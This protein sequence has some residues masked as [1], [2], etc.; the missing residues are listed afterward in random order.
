[1]DTC[2]QIFGEK[3]GVIEV[4]SLEESSDP[5]R[6]VFLAEESELLDAIS[7]ML[8][9]AIERKQ[10]E[11]ELREQVDF[12]NRLT[13]MVPFGITLIDA[14]DM[15]IT[16]VNRVAAGIIGL[17][18][19]EI[20]GRKCYELICSNKEMCVLSKIVNET[21]TVESSIINSS[22]DPVPI[23]KTAATIRLNQRECILDCFVDISE[24]KKSEYKANQL[25]EIVEKADEGIAI[26]N[27]DGEIQYANQEWVRLHGYESGAQLKGE[28][29]SIF[30][31]EKQ[32]REEILPFNEIVMQCG[33]LTGE[34]GHMRKDGTIFEA[35]NTVTLLKDE[36]GVPHTL[37]N[38]TQDITGRKVIENE[39][40]Q[41]RKFNA[42][43]QLA[44]GIAHEVNTPIQYVGDNT[45]FLGE[46][47]QALSA[48]LGMY[49]ELR[50][51]TE[52]GEVSPEL[53]ERVA[54]AV[55][56]ADVPYLMEEIPL[57]LRQTIEGIDHVSKIV[58]A[59]KE[60]SHPGSEDMEIGDIN[61]ILET[62]ITL[63]RNE[64]KYTADLK[65]S[66][67]P[68]LPGIY[69]LPTEM[70]QVF[71]NIIL[72]AAHAV[73]EKNADTGTKGVITVKTCLKDS[74][75][76][77]QIEDDGP[78][79]PGNIRDRVMEPFFTTKEVGK[80]SGQGLAIARSVVVDKHGGKFTFNTEEGKGTVFTIQLPFTEKM[81]PET[82][83]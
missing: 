10:V 80:G 70:S 4:Y 20:I 81:T 83:R 47:F 40:E 38:F 60:F 55:E 69:C 19:Q 52:H 29:W 16:M 30:H 54:A 26:A 18:P 5:D 56:D 78:G 77:I 42:V 25:A 14:K 63:S 74:F 64:W 8:G 41:S 11:M 17:P 45:R 51:A 15:E 49:E 76:K 32:M 53:V 27:L 82:V 58:L 22:G 72:N 39:L 7:N 13:M 31:S 67:D 6:E 75:V 57:A 65:T 62:T 79:V 28:H 44:A 46:S 48:V 23:I 21:Y 1:M 73:G 50:E 71:L 33:H 68:E 2:I 59:M 34:A 61:K 9:A 36:K 12:T 43:G 66:L 3:R 35:L 24:K 37:V